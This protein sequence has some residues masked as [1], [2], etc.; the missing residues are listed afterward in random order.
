M[1]GD[2]A[3]PDPLVMTTQMTPPQNQTDSVHANSCRRYGHASVVLGATIAALIAWTSLH[4]GHADLAVHSGGDVRQIGA[5]A[6]GVTTVLVG[7][8]AWGLL[9]LIQKR[10][11]RPLRVWVPIALAVFVISLLGPLSGVTFSDKAALAGLHASV[12]AILI[13]GMS[14]AGRRC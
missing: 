11:A 14:R 12:A 1:F 7:L 13:I 9:A 4:L 10:T 3:P 5:V 6:V 8:A 2:V